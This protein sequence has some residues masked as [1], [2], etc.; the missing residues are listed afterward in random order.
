MLLQLFTRSPEW[1][2]SPSFSFPIHV[3][4]AITST[5]KLFG[6][7]VCYLLICFILVKLLLFERMISSHPIYNSLFISICSFL[8][9][10]TVNVS[11]TLKFTFLMKIYNRTPALTPI[12]ILSQTFPHS[13][14]YPVTLQHCIGPP[15]TYWGFQHTVN[16][17]W[18]GEAYMGAGEAV[19]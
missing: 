17:V 19:L 5:E 11:S 3:F 18:E 9:C 13:S 8:E 1:H 4:Q 6:L 14:T 10:T 7:F 2:C 15:S 16:H 12:S